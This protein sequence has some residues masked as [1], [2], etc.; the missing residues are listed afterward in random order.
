MIIQIPAMAGTR[1][2]IIPVANPA[3]SA[4]SFPA[5]VI[6]SS[7]VAAIAIIRKLFFS[8]PVNPGKTNLFCMLTY[9]A[10]KILKK[11][12]AVCFQKNYKL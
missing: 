4:T 8:A 1:E 2:N 10:S 9:S 6:L 3:A 7:R 11:L 12:Q 5:P